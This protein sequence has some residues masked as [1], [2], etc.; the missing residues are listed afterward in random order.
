MMSMKFLFSRARRGLVGAGL[1]LLVALAVACGGGG[2]SSGDPRPDPDPGQGFPGLPG[3]MEV[4]ADAKRGDTVLTVTVENATLS[5][6]SDRS[7]F[8]SDGGATATISLTSNATAIFDSDNKAAPLI[9]TAANSVS[10]ATAT[11][12]FVSAPR[13]ITAGLL[14]TLFDALDAVTGATILATGAAKISIWHNDAA[15]ERYEISPDDGNFGVNSATGLVTAMTD[16]TPESTYNLTLRLVDRALA[17]T[18]SRS[19]RV[20]VGVL[21]PLEFMDLPASPVVAA[22]AAEVG[23]AALVITVTGA[24]LPPFERSGFGSDGGEMATISLA[25]DPA[26]IFTF[27]NAIVSL[28]ITLSD[29]RRTIAATVRFMSAPRVI[30]ADL[31]PIPVAAMD[32][33]AG[34]TILAAG[35][36]EISIW[37][38]G[39]AAIEEYEIS[40]D[41]GNF[42]VDS[43]TGLVTATTDLTPGDNYDL[44]LHLIDRGLALTASRSLRAVVGV[45]PPLGFVDLPAS[46][47]VAAAADIG[48]AVLTITAAGAALPSFARSGFMSD[49]GA[50]ATISL[51]SEATVVFDSDNAIASLALTLASG[52]ETATATIR[53]VSAPRVIAA[54]PAT[55]SVSFIDAIA[56]GTILATGAAGVSIWHNSAGDRYEI[57]SAGG[58]FGVDSATGLVTVAMDLTAGNSYDFTLRVIDDALSLTASRSLRAVAVNLEPLRLR[59]LSTV[60]WSRDNAY[61]YLVEQDGE[62]IDLRVVGG[63]MM[64]GATRETAFPIYNIWQLQAIEGLQ[65][66]SSGSFQIP[67]TPLFGANRLSSHYRLM[68]DIDAGVTKEWVSSGRGGRRPGQGFNPIGNATDDELLKGGLYGDGYAIRDL[69]INRPDTTYVGLFAIASGSVIESVGIENARIVGL[70]SVGALA[71][72]LGL[73]VIQ[74]AWVSGAVTGKENVGG[75]VGDSANSRIIESRSLATVTGEEHIGGLIGSSIIGGVASSWST[76]PVRGGINVG[77]LIGFHSGT[78]INRNWSIAAVTGKE[79]VGGLIGNIV[80]AGAVALNWSAGSARGDFG[81]GGL[82]GRNRHAEVENN[83]S[84]ASASGEQFVGGLLGRVENSIINHVLDNWSGGAVAAQKNGGGMLGYATNPAIPRPYWSRETSGIDFDYRASNRRL[85]PQSRFGGHSSMQEVITP[86]FE[87][88]TWHND[89]SD[90]SDNAADFPVLATLDIG[91]QWAGLAYGLTRVLASVDGAEMAEW[92]ERREMSRRA[93]TIRI[94]TNAMAPDTRAEGGVTSTPDCALVGGV[95]RATTNYNSAIVLA[96]AEGGV[97]SSVS[98]CEAVLTPNAGARRATLHLAFAAA[99]ATLRRTHEMRYFDAGDLA[100]RADFLASVEWSKAYARGD[101]D[102][103]GIPNAYDY[104]P[105]GDAFDLRFDEAGRFTIFGRYTMCGSCRRST[106]KHR[107]TRAERTYSGFRSRFAWAV[108]IV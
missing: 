28:T 92:G 95:L 26:E 66:D 82:I 39:A 45:L 36:A 102:D 14:L 105:R 85:Y 22:A 4:A 98:G 44:T 40:P 107:T 97:L 43:A 87:S 15:N 23:D 27:D 21:P 9:L 72:E 10:A 86:L 48:D 101:E 106:E 74:N 65:E 77:G 80:S 78:S 91:L 20:T 47:V 38:N 57:S 52:A 96:R 1:L 61:D 63:V 16:L 34:A 37:H 83:W 24:T 89:D 31:L 12:R 8:M 94:D 51:A 54:A 59:Y 6:F 93:V 29:S 5:A 81:I 67:A 56:G 104:R 73:G 11:I 41:D 99:G 35:A 64:D 84:V 100:A 90:L 71:G 76:G 69:W 75:L 49:G 25:S 2:G 62:T 42:G 7:G 68:N 17:L 19:L 13:V 18:A 108:G 46:V 70:R 53:F 55:I 32:A 79:N 33:V 88:D 103:D 60:E 50:M 58:F 3:Q 30:T